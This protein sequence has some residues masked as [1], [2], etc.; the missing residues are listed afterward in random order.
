MAKIVIKN[1]NQ[2]LCHHFKIASTFFERLIGL[3]F[4][5][6]IQPYDGLL[7]KR[8]KSIH[9]CFMRY[10]IDVVFLDRKYKVVKVIPSMKPWRLTSFYWRASQVL[11]LPSG[12]LR[13]Q[14]KEG[15][16][17]EVQCIN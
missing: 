17:L 15:D 16:C 10:A 2:I 13:G 12:S 5:Q 8:C 9:T 14:I 6:S 3:M 1:T 4:S 11:E 7:I